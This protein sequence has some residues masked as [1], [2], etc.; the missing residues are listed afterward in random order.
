MVLFP[1]TVFGDFS[2]AFCCPSLAWGVGVSSCRWVLWFLFSCLA[3]RTL[4]VLFFQGQAL[5][6][7][8]RLHVSGTSFH[9]RRVLQGCEVFLL[10]YMACAT[11][12]SSV[13]RV[14][15]VSCFH[16][17]HSLIQ[18]RLRF[19]SW[20]WMLETPKKREAKVLRGLHKHPK[21]HIVL[22]IV[23]CHL[24]CKSLALANEIYT[25]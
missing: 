8:T 24:A 1:C 21:F 23:F 7:C 5:H 18:A 19:S 17:R 6:S 22:V 14:L 20:M 4:A 25:F 16:F 9:D 3:S 15:C 11:S 10:S 12:F 13:R 2:Q